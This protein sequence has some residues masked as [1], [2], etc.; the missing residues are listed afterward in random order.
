[1][2]ADGSQRRWQ[3]HHLSVP[4]KPR[5]EIEILG[6]LGPEELFESPDR[7]ERGARCHETRSRE[8]KQFAAS[9]GAL[10]LGVNWFAR[11]PEDPAVARDVAHATADAGHLRVLIEKT[12]LHGELWR[13]PYVICVEKR[14][15]PRRGSGTHTG[16][17]RVRG[18]PIGSGDDEDAC[19]SA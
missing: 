8:R 5:I 6:A 9:D 7:V 3:T 18:A 12:G 16:V 4:G 19:V 11:L 13:I 10:L 1:M 15:V 2:N 17:S 14:D